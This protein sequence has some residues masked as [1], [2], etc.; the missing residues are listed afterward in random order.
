MQHETYH[1]QWGGP[2][3]PAPASAQF[4]GGHS[5]VP[6][7]A[8]PGWFPKGGEILAGPVAGGDGG[9]GGIN[10]GN[11]REA[12]HYPLSLPGRFCP[13]HPKSAL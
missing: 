9:Q 13:P 8:H 3:E 10:L 7:S 6:G 12:G 11:E 4:C 2:D 1:N 5:A